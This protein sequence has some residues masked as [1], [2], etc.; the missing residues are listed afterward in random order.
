MP[1][2][3][4]SLLVHQGGK[5][6]VGWGWWCAELGDWDWHVYTDVYKIDD[7]LKKKQK[8]KQ[9][10]TEKKKKSPCPNTVHK[11]YQH[12]PPI[13]VEPVPLNPCSEKSRKKSKLKW[14]GPIFPVISGAESPWGDFEPNR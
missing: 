14:Q 12:F 10:S 1:L 13:I 4:K 3:I 9:N 11:R 8:Q 5:T 7:W 2:H 6:V